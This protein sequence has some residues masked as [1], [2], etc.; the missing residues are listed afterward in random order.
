MSISLE[1]RFNI[2]PRGVVSKKYMGL[3]SILRLKYQK[4][5]IYQCVSL[6]KIDKTYN[7]KLYIVCIHNEKIIAD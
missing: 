4:M 3:L 2:R 7:G 1:K 5:S 6:I